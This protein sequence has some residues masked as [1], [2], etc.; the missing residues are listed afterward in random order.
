MTPKHEGNVGSDGSPLSFT[1]V[2]VIWPQVWQAS[3]LAK[4]CVNTQG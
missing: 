3:R 2:P 4:P 1:F